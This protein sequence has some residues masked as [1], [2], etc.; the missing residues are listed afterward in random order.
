MSLTSNTN[1]GQSGGFGPLVANSG[2]Q[3][4]LWTQF[5]GAFNDNVY[6]MIV[7]LRAVHVA[8]GESS[9]Y[10]SLAGAVFVIPFLLFSGYSG[11]L[12]DRVSKRR[13]LVG[14]KV[15][16]VFVMLLGI[17]AF[18]SARIELMLVVLFLMALHSTVFSPAKYGIVPEMLP[19]TEL[20]RANA[21]LEMSTFVAIV[22]GTAVG[23][24]LFALWKDTPWYLGFVMTGVSVIG[25]LTS[26]RITRVPASGAEQRFD[27]NPFAEVITG[28]RHLIADRP[29]FLTV[30]AISYFW[31]LGALFQ[32]DLLLFGSEVLKVDELRVSLMVTALAIGIGVGS[33]LSGR[34]S[35]SKVEIG[36]VPLGSGL[37]AVFSV[38]LWAAS[39]SYGWSVAVLSLLGVASGIFIVPLNAYL[40]QR[41]ESR[42][43]GRIIA[44]NNIWNTFGLLLAS[45]VLWVLHDKLG[46]RPDRLI[47]VFGVV[48]FGATIWMVRV[49]PEFLVRFLFWMLTHTMYRIRI[50]GRENLPLQGPALLVSNHMTFVD[51]MLLQASVQR[52]IHFMIWKPFYEHP[53]LRGFFRLAKAIPVGSG[54]K[55]LL[56]SFQAARRDLEQGHVVCI[57]PEGGITRTGNLQPFKRGIEKILDGVDV[58]VIPVHLGGVWQSLF[59]YSEG[60]FFWKRPRRPLAPVMVSYGKP[61]PSSTP[62]D[63]VR[64]AILEL[65]SEAMEERKR[66][67]DTLPKRFARNA[68]RHW[69]RFAMADSTGRE[70]TYGQ[71]LTASVLVAGWVRRNLADQPMVGVMLPASVGGA[72]AN[73]GLSMAGRVP[74]NL[75]FTSGR[76]ALATAV[77]QCGIRT[78]ITSKL[79]L[80]KAKLERPE[81]AV[82]LE[83]LL[84]GFSKV[85]KVGALLKAR[86]LP[87]SLLAAACDPDAP[88]TVVF[89]SG[90]TGVPKGVVLSHW[91]VISNIES[92]TQVYWI[93]ER[94][95][96]VGVLP[97]FHSFG[98]TVT[99]W[100]PLVSG[101]GAVY[102]ANPT[103]AKVI[104]EL[105]EKHQGTFLL[106]T[107]TFCSSYARNCTR[108]QFASLRFVLVGAER[109]R[110][111]V[112]EAFR[113]AFGKELLEGYGCTEM[114]PVVA[115]NVPHWENG[116]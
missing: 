69:N 115:V 90:S 86:L 53:M 60:R 96:I 91:N 95:R 100:L 89:S 3:A 78:V 87:L 55:E 21:L 102:H 29:L 82:F 75:N 45:G 15:F 50:L 70:L 84:A 10:L 65:G 5:L 27:W 92:M 31:F 2:F 33:M 113:E 43:K 81:G 79:F 24:G 16:E 49:V 36:L 116:R 62:V 105:I 83:D 7:S 108:E 18:F 93:N 111:S 25:L 47:L 64:Q 13:V 17:A 6:K 20:S 32:M 66:P 26:L 22:L 46:V 54:P 12:A 11:H 35:G 67:S 77:Q 94:D 30:L 74:V 56:T 80:A 8:A 112:A 59:A 99:L 63:G 14:V 109:L 61:L 51:G 1:S 4:F 97:F 104:G 110:E 114:A 88:A 38:A 72:L 71:A 9:L 41:A 48:T 106:S 52:F 28:T 76:E 19:E 58:P 42:E 23:G 85:R 37:M 57:F 34:L 101:C 44:T 40:Q 98:Y 68:K 73:T 39:G 107:P 103:E